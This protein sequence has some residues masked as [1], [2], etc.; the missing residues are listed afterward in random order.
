[1]KWFPKQSVCPHCQTVY[2][3]AD[4][5]R[6]TWKRQAPCYHCQKMMTV[7]RKSLWILAAETALVYLILNIV[8]LNAVRGVSF[9][10]LLLVN[11][12]PAL[13][14]VL[15]LPGYIELKHNI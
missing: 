13:A 1:M 12:L 4:V 10:G 14:A 9:F 2:R 15:L 7:S 6:L 8:M 11:C 5:K 3:Y